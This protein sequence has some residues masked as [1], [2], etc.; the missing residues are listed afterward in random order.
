MS[1]ILAVLVIQAQTVWI[2]RFLILVLCI[3]WLKLL[4]SQWVREPKPS[5]FP[6]DSFVSEKAYSIIL[7]LGGL[8]HKHGD[9][10]P[11]PKFL[12]QCFTARATTC[13]APYL[14]LSVH[15]GYPRGPG[16]EAWPLTGPQFH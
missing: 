8:G 7:R 3:H 1:V 9:S 10:L 12:V 6:I 2:V 13:P 11:K 15:S 5:S 16:H 4:E 14:G